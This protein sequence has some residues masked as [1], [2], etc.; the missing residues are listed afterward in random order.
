MCT[1]VVRLLNW[2]A[3]MGKAL[4]LDTPEPP[5]DHPVHI[6]RFR[7]LQMFL[8]YF[9]NSAKKDEA[10]SMIF[11]LQD[12]GYEYLSAKLYYTWEIIWEIT[13]VITAQN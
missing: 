8:E 1:R 2:H 9:P 13:C 4:Y 12:V 3:S 10:Q 6:A 5:F 7:K 11:T